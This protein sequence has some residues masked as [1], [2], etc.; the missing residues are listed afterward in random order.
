MKGS[1]MAHVKKQTDF[2]INFIN[3]FREYDVR[4]RLTDEELNV[5][6]VHRIVY[7]YALLI[8]QRGIKRA[9]VGYDNRD[10]SPSFAQAAIK[11]LR[12]NGIDVWY[13]G[14]CTTPVVYFAQYYLQC[15]GAVMI[16][17]SHNPSDWSGF[18]FGKG[19]S[20][21]LEAPD[22]I[23]LFNLLDVPAS[24]VLPDDDPAMGELHEVDVRD[25]Y[26]DEIVSRLHMGPKKLR[27]VIDAG[28]GSAGVFAY[29]LFQRL[30]CMTFQLY[31]DPDT[32]YPQYFPNPSDMKARARVRE[33]VLHPYI[34]ADLGLSFDGD[35]DRVGVIDAQGNDVWSDTV[36]AVLAKQ[37][38]EKKPGCTIVYDVKCSKK[39]PEVIEA[40]GGNPIMWKTGHSYIKAKMHEIGAE[41]AGERS[42]HIFVGGDDYFGFDDGIFVAAKHVEYLSNIDENL[43][44]VISAFPQ[45]VTSPEIKAYCP[46]ELKYEVSERIVARFKEEF[47]GQVCDINGARVDF[48]DSWGLVRPS[49]NLPEFALVFEGDTDESMR[50]AHATFKRILSEF[51]EIATEWGNDIS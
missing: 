36:V 34:H 42:G 18:K 4:G 9:V 31:C 26:L 50:R 37:L 25:A 39:V 22:I 23:D 40:Y 8:K 28:N 32:S 24:E 6:N 45:Y 10:C 48:G 47:P 1:T 51:P 29:E 12:K 43:N 30:G 44:E 49:S 33:M 20:K 13:V 38:L 3:M 21:T 46:D 14:M 19:Y 7:A 16:T 11:A 2:P 35:G 27:V 41:L 17:A 5:K 15:E